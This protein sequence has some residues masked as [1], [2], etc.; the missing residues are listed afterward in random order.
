MGNYLWSEI[1]S[2][3]MKFE[4]IF[5]SFTALVAVT[6]NVTFAVYLI[7]C[8]GSP[9]TDVFLRALWQFHMDT[10]IRTKCKGKEQKLLCLLFTSVVQWMCKSAEFCTQPSAGCNSTSVQQFHA[11]AIRF[12]SETSFHFQWHWGT[13]KVKGTHP[14]TALSSWCISAG[15][16]KSWYPE[17]SAPTD[18]EIW[19]E[20]VSLTMQLLAWA[21]DPSC[22]HRVGPHAI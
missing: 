4:A 5:P 14:F 11:I 21:N 18:P 6:H 15:W 2:N 12:D 10:F 1:N 19:I 22:V 9:Q 16:V 8:E 3:G 13:E 7:C 17:I 20:V